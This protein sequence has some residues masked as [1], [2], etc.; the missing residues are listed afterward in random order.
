MTP[1][2]KSNSK[3]V[4]DLNVRLKTI[5]PLEQNIEEKLHDIGYGNEFMS[6]MPEPQA[7]TAKLNNCDQIK[8]KVFTI[9]KGAL[10]KMDVDNLQNRK[11]FA[12]HISGKG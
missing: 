5:K 3:S 8:L 4:E 12:S 7:P 9:A 10:R 1:C 6:V 11:T 2:M